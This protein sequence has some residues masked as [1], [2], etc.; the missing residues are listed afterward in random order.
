MVRAGAILWIT[1]DNDSD[2]VATVGMARLVKGGL[3][4]CIP[5][6]EGQQDYHFLK[7]AGEPDIR[8]DEI[9]FPGSDAE[10]LPCQR[11]T[12]IPYKKQKE[13]IEGWNEYLDAN[14]DELVLA[15]ERMA[16]ECMG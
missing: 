12:P 9:V 4:W 8:G 13:F 11:Y 1:R 6:P 3:L 7:F 16:G 14:R 10:L 2:I 15:F 5:F